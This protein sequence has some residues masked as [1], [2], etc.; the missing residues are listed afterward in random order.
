LNWSSWLNAQAWLLPALNM[1]L[2][3]ELHLPF[4]LRPCCGFGV[5]GLTFVVA[6]QWAHPVIVG[7]PVTE[8]ANSSQSLPGAA[9]T[10]SNDAAAIK[11]PPGVPDVSLPLASVDSPADWHDQPFGI[12]AANVTLGAIDPK[13]RWVLFCQAEGSSNAEPKAEAQK[14]ADVLYRREK[15]K[16]YFASGNSGTRSVVALLASSPNGRYVVISTEAQGPEL[17]DIQTKQSESL[18]QADL[19]LR[20]DVLPGDLRSVAFS[21][22][23]SKLALLV[24]EKRPRVIVRDL[25]KTSVSEVAPLGNWVWRIAFDA[26]GQFVVLQE[27]LEDSNRNG[28]FEWPVPEQKLS[29]TRCTTPIP[30]Y[31]AWLPSGDEAQVT[32]ASVGGGTARAVPGFLTGLGASLIAKRPSGELSAIEGSRTKTIS[33]T[34]CQANIIAIAPQYGRILTGCRDSRGRS[35]V[36]LDSLDS[37]QQLNFDV[38]SSS[39]DW[40]NP[41]RTRYAVLYSGVHS[42]I[43]DIAAAELIGLEERDQ[44]LAEGKLGLLLRRGSTV[45]LYDPS[46]G[47]K[48]HLLEDVRPGTR[49]VM[50]EGTV[51]VGQSVISADQGLV[52]G[53][54]SN[55][56]LALASTGC[57]LAALGGAPDARR[58]ARGPLTW[59]CPSPKP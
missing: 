30:G 41:E 43:V 21:P 50:G 16:P 49:L 38:P 23:S 10:K 6:C 32:I 40:T 55:P 18:T 8:P 24:H 3:I 48:K 20:A 19:D 37:N 11:P 33:S 25:E 2:N 15:L 58:F 44:V 17:L 34:D 13:G 53:T 35:N 56:V 4:R 14:S 28:R 46:T 29:E 22:D 5:V 27:I 45:M 54:V 1:N 12:P 42:Y 9:R 52:L 51:L 57:A 47:A 36:E 26:S 39:V 7:P 59:T 31:S